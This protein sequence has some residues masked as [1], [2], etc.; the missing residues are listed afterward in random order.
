MFFRPQGDMSARRGNGHAMA[1][2]LPDLN[3]NDR[4]AVESSSFAAPVAHDQKNRKMLKI[5]T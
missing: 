2:A 1:R 3:R 4:L 5:P